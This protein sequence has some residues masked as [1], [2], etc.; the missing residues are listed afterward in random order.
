M[1]GT[2][3]G[4]WMASAAQAVETV[5]NHRRIHLVGLSMGGLISI[6]LAKSTAAA[7]I[8]TINSPVI[9]H[10]LRLYLAPLMHRRRPRVIWPDRP[11]PRLD[12]EVSSYWLTYPGFP[13]RTGGDLVRL[14]WLA[15]G[16]A[17]RLRR[18]AL[19]IQTRTDEA[20]FPVSGAILAR[21]LGPRCRLVWLTRSIHNS[22]LDSERDVIH[23]AVLARVSS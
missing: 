20:V 16:A 7:T 14:S 5:A 6:L 22:L 21:A 9:V 10:D 2:G 23:R 11:P 17:T 12:D 4:D 18:P 8:T 3:A 19:V 1:S 13:T 15:I